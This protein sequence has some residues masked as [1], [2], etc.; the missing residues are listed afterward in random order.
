MKII[1][2]NAELL[3]HDIPAYQF[4]EKVGR[5]CYKSEDK[6]TD[7][8]AVNFVKALAK[9]KHLAML[10]HEYL[11]LFV[12]CPRF[13]H[14]FAH[15]NKITSGYDIASMRYFNINELFISGSFRSW[16]ELFNKIRF[17][18]IKVSSI[19][20]YIYKL[21]NNK[22]P[23]IFNDY[24]YYLRDNDVYEYKDEDGKIIRFRYEDYYGNIKI[25]SRE[26]IENFCREH[27]EPLNLLPHTIKFTC[28]RGVSHE[29]VRHRPASFAQEST[30]YCNYSHDKFGNEITFIKPPF[31]DLKVDGNGDLWRYICE[32]SEK[33]YFTM[34]KE[35]ATPEQARSILPNSLKTELII[36][37]TEEE[38]QHIVNLRYH[39]TTG[40]PHPQMKEVMDIAYPLLVQSSEG[41]IQ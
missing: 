4:I 23:E 41:R 33:M 18:K 39:G 16:I 32:E 37:A 1:K 7:T 9:N 40:K 24:Y 6:I 14:E 11:Y 30:R 17:G 3:A 2:P 38:W 19:F 31:W 34:L 8:S 25:I 15:I 22:Y 36:T 21:L 13:F 26:E 12:V 5:T 35:G 29:F 28:D 27:P 20:V 10:E